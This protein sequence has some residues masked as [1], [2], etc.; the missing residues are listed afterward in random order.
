MVLAPSLVISYQLSNFNECLNC[1][2]M[3]KQTDTSKWYWSQYL[4]KLAEVI[5]TATENWKCIMLYRLNLEKLS[6]SSY[7]YWMYIFSFGIGF[8]CVFCN[9]FYTISTICVCRI[10]CILNKISRNGSK[11]KC[12]FKIRAHVIKQRLFIP[13][14]LLLSLLLTSVIK[15]DTNQENCGADNQRWCR[16]CRIYQV[17][18]K[19]KGKLCNW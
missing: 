9:M 18:R 2:V 10:S 15:I 1:W 4:P 13:D 3:L 16:T 11:G 12:Q 6:N 17:S 14:L 8:L 19:W 5:T 7:F